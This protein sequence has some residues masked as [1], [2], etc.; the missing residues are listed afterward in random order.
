MDRNAWIAIA[1]IGVV[2]LLTP[3]WE[4]WLN[5][6]PPVKPVTKQQVQVDTVI[7]PKST[8]PAEIRSDTTKIDFHPK[9][10]ENIAWSM[11]SSDP[12]KGIT[13]IETPLYTAVLAWDGARFVSWKLKPNGKYI[14]EPTELIRPQGYG[15]V[16]GAVFRD[17]GVRSIDYL[18][19]SSPDTLVK[20]SET[21]SKSVTLHTQ[22]DPIGPVDII[23]TFKGNDFAFDL[24]AR[25]TSD[26]PS[27][28]G[29]SGV[30]TMGPGLFPTEDARGSSSGKFI[31]VGEEYYFG[32]HVWLG[33]VKHG[34]M[35]E[36]SPKPDKTDKFEATGM[37]LWGA[38]RS[39]YFV[40]AVEP[41]K[42]ATSVLA[43]SEAG[44]NAAWKTQRIQMQVPNAGTPGVFQARVYIGPLKASNVNAFAP[45]LDSIMNWGWWFI[46]KPF[47]KAT[48]WLL[49]F[50]Y[51]FITNYG[52]V[53]LVF[54][55]IIK[56]LLWPLTVKQFRS[57]KEMQLI[58]PLL[59]EVR[60]KYKDNPKKM[61]EETFKL[62]GEY[63]VNPA[64]GCL[65]MIL[66][67][68]ILYAL[69]II[70]RSTIELRDAPFML[71]I[72]DLSQPE[73]L[74]YLPF[75]VPLYG[76][77]V[78]L[79]PIA[80]GITQFFMG[81]QTASTDPNQKMMLYMMPVMMA[82]LFNSFPAGL[83]L[84]YMFYN[85]ATIVQQHYIRG[86]TDKKIPTTLAVTSPQ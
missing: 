12:A 51:T 14:K 80:M 52:I 57:M 76:Q 6:K 40:V 20:L 24:T 42:P 28:Q 72:K 81:K 33:D 19:F 67:M 8:I 73:A 27:W 59:K 75:H 63:K 41:I 11:R 55:I 54:T 79:L 47:S 66:Q 43:Q 48:L 50:L 7:V 30:W 61:N 25:F 65:P 44:P 58:Q 34:E 22:W 68:P 84:Y 35:E 60:E 71:W 38:Q 70:F 69:F 78:A 4:E 9:T 16:P 86:T 21:D 36:F 17:G 1:L 32:S 3:Y 37:T 53:I 49:T 62:Y 10:A 2:I 64:G 82:A 46:V 85:L 13:R 26:N 77:N 74:F 18:T 56:G 39:K 5:P 15:I 45:N 31:N 29:E 83:V 23:Y